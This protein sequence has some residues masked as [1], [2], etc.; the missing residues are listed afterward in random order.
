MS[1]SVWPYREKQKR[2]VFPSQLK[3]LA[4][5]NILDKKLEG[6]GA[7]V[8]TRKQAKAL[9]GDILTHIDRKNIS[10]GHFSYIL[11]SRRV[12]VSR[13]ADEP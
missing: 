10:V 2:V 9:A 8:Q 7:I 4:G 6:M 3:D 1:A 13:K 11:I 12:A 5:L